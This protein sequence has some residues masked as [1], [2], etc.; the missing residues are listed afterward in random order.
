MNPEYDLKDYKFPNI[1]SKP[2]GKVIYHF[3]QLFPE[4]DPLLI[5]LL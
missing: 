5:S 1:K 2:F 3:I 4:T